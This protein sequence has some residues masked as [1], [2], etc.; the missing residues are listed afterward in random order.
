MKG[1]NGKDFY[2]LIEPFVSFLFSLNFIIFFCYTILINKNVIINQGMINWSVIV[3]SI[4]FIW[5]SYFHFMLLTFFKKR[6]IYFL[7]LYD[8]FLI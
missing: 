4:L 1:C 2:Y 8:I 5:F 3:L 7:F 6:I